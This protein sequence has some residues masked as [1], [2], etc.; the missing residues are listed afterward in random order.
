MRLIK[1]ACFNSSNRCSQW[2]YPQRTDI[3]RG[4]GCEAL[5]NH[6]E[7]KMGKTSKLGQYESESASAGYNAGFEIST[8]QKHVVGYQCN[9]CAARDLHTFPQFS[10]SDLD[11]KI[12]CRSD[13]CVSFKGTSCHNLFPI[14]FYRTCKANTDYVNF[15][16]FSY[17][18]HLCVCF[19]GGG[20]CVRMCVRDV[21]GQFLQSGLQLSWSQFL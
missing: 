21:M 6:R 17:M 11:T 2:N 5:K 3:Q 13:I 4:S 8:K 1:N 7:E 15:D 19:F 18:H 14:S 16:Y 10:I 20:N 9:I 12:Q